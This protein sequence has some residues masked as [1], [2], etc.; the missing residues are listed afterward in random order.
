M[1]EDIYM[2]SILDLRERVTQ[3]L[4]MDVG[5]LPVETRMGVID[6]DI[7][8]LEL[9]Q[10][11]I[12]RADLKR[13]GTTNRALAN[14]NEIMFESVIRGV[15]G[16]LE[17]PKV[18]THEKDNPMGAVEG[19]AWLRKRKPE[20]NYVDLRYM[21]LVALQWMMLIGREITGQYNLEQRME[22]INGEEEE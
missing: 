13:D 1:H 20:A 2:I 4:N 10:Y 11:L 6:D 8:A 12:E 22:T 5:Y 16:R 3:S 7:I 14:M 17:P 18:F 9:A 19:L 15:P 21:T